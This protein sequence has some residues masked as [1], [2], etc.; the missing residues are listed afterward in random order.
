MKDI[1]EDYVEITS[2]L[3]KANPKNVLIQPIVYNNSTLAIFELAT[4]TTF[5]DQHL[6][7]LELISDNIATKLSSFNN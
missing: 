4:F 5:S 7:L 3:G 1:P 6:K 2:G